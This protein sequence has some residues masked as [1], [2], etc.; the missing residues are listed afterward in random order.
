MMEKGPRWLLIAVTVTVLVL[1]WH[2]S[3]W[4]AG[5]VTTPSQNRPSCNG[6]TTT[7][8]A[9]GSIVCVG[10]LDGDG[11]QEVVVVTGCLTHAATAGC[12]AGS[13]RLV[14][15]NHDGTIRAALNV[16]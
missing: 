14:I 7:V 2:V 16:P 8:A 12:P 4:S 6:A 9:F 15:F 5:T 11:R 10:D 1:G 3:L 13:E